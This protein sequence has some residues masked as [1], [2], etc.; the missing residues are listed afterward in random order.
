M[1]EAHAQDFER[2]RK[3][4]APEPASPYHGA[5]TA[6]DES[7]D[8]EDGDV[9]GVEIEVEEEDVGEARVEENRREEDEQDLLSARDILTR[10][11]SATD[12]Q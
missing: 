4:G 3:S 6:D 10:H 7:S 11:R 12:P 2:K 1:G 5:R 8:E 9:A